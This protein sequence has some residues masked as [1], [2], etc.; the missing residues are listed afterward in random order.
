VEKP[1]TTGSEGLRPLRERSLQHLTGDI[2]TWQAGS[3][4]GAGNR[5]PPG[6]EPRYRAGDQVHL[7][8]VDQVARRPAQASERSPCS[9]ITLNF[10]SW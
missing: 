9:Q 3:T 1:E 8:H 7:V 6:P 4:I 5:R 2:Q 10:K